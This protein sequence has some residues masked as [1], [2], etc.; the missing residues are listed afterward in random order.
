MGRN[1][2]WETMDGVHSSEEAEEAII[3][4]HIQI[5]P[6]CLWSSL[7]LHIVLHLAPMGG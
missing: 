6:V 4:T 1:F 5:M 7:D 3:I 2:R